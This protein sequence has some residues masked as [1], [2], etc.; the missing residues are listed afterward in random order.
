MSAGIGMDPLYIRHAITHPDMAVDPDDGSVY[1]APTF[2]N[3]VGEYSMSGTI[4]NMK[5][6]ADGSGIAWGSR[7]SLTELEYN[8]GDVIFDHV[9]GEH[10]FFISHKLG[11]N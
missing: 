9:S 10:V 8:G 6:L 7:G 11:E 3:T 2:L 1:V 4:Y 5:V